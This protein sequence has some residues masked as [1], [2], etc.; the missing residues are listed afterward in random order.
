MRLEAAL[1]FQG[2]WA[3]KIVFL[4]AEGHVIFAPRMARAIRERW[5]RIMDPTTTLRGPGLA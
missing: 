2:S 5:I 3:K 1:P 4:D